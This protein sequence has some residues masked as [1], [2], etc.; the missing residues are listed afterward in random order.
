LSALNDRA[1]RQIPIV[2]VAKEMEHFRVLD[3]LGNYEGAG[4]AGESR[5]RHQHCPSARLGRRAGAPPK[6]L[7][8]LDDDVLWLEP[9]PLAIDRTPDRR[10]PA[11]R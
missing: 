1:R 9:S 11:P 8:H 2:D 5:H 6:A 10:A 3:A 4:L 7:R